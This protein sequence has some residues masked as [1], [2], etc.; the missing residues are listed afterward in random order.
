M[1]S[2]PQSGSTPSTGNLP[3]LAKDH[4]RSPMRGETTATAGYDSVFMLESNFLFPENGY[5]AR[6]IS[7]RPL[8]FRV[9]GVLAQ[10]THAGRLR[11]SSCSITPGRL[12]FPLPASVRHVE[13]VAVCKKL[14]SSNGHGHMGRTMCVCIFFG[15]EFSDKVSGGGRSAFEGTI[16]LVREEA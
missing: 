2:G 9:I 7:S 11:L 6:A 16:G 4:P 13:M 5:D 1:C 12:D 3:T 14:V 15:R 10:V 8:R